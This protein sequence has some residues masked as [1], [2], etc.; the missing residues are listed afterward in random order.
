MVGRARGE[1]V[2][3]LQHLRGASDEG[4]GGAGSGSGGQA[5]QDVGP[6]AGGNLQEVFK[7]T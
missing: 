3:R 6:R 4:G 2:D 7:Q 1:H 5:G